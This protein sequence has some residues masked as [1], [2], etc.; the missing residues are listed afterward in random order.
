[1]TEAMTLFRVLDRAASAAVTACGRYDPYEALPK[2]ELIRSACYARCSRYGTV[3]IETP[4][5]AKA[6]SECDLWLSRTRRWRETWLEVKRAWAGPTWNN[7]PSEQGAGW[8]ADIQKLADAGQGRRAFFLLSFMNA[9][10]GRVLEPGYKAITSRLSQARD[11]EHAIGSS[12]PIE[13]G[14][15]THQLQARIWWWRSGG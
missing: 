2:E 3:F 11:L 8:L 7:K 5:T 13:W 14:R 10:H 1:M 12:R 6:R 15:S 4:Y 9:E